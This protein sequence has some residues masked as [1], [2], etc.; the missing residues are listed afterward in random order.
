MRAPLRYWK[1]NGITS[2]SRVG[3]SETLH[4]VLLVAI[5][6]LGK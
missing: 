3:L 1:E 2:A 4:H 6:V 5:V